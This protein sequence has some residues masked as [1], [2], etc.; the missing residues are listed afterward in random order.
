MCVCVS[1]GGGGGCVCPLCV[2]ERSDTWSPNI[3][4]EEAD[5]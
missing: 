5:I 2:C 4:G 1:G 3:P